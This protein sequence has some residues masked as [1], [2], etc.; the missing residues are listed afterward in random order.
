MIQLSIVYSVAALKVLPGQ[1]LFYLRIFSK[2]VF[3]KT[4]EN[5]LPTPLLMYGRD[6]KSLHFIIVLCIV[7]RS[8]YQ[9]YCG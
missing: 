2:G 3:L 8:N 4:V 6:K 5:S 1:L 9:A 7:L